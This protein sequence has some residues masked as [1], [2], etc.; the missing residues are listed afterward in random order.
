MFLFCFA[1]KWQFSFG[2]SFRGRETGVGVFISPDRWD[3]SF[4]YANHDYC[5]RLDSKWSSR[6]DGGLIQAQAGES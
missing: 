1:L 6:S 4:L 5:G 2:S 3:A